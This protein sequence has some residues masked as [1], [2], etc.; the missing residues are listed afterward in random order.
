MTALTKGK[1]AAN[2]ANGFFLAMAL[3]QKGDKDEARKWF[4]KAV[5]CT[6]EKDPKDVELRQFWAE[7]ADLL[8]RPSPE[9]TKGGTAS[10]ETRP[11]TPR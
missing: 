5:A 11:G 9:H 10:A 6:K 8:G 3:W 2:A 4:D 7:A 1:G